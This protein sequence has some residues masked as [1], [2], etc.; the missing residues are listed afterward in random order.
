MALVHFC[1]GSDSRDGDIDKQVEK[2]CALILGPKRLKAS[3]CP[4]FLPT[5][6]NSGALFARPSSAKL[7]A[8]VSIVLDDWTS[9]PPVT[10]LPMG[11]HMIC[12]ANL[13]LNQIKNWNC[14]EHYGRLAI[15]FTDQFRARVGAK[16]VCYY[17][18]LDLPHDPKVV[19][20]TQSVRAQN[21]DRCL[22]SELLSYRKPLKLWR[23]FKEYFSVISVQNTTGIP[24]LEVLPYSRYPTGYEFV[25]ECEARIVLEADAEFLSFLPTDVLKIYAPTEKARIDIETYL[26]THWDWQPPVELCP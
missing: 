22:E 19:A 16:N 14:K 5:T 2:A 4:E 18:W 1:F 10:L 8:D 25:K 23:A 12:F 11:V 17:N 7:Q 6:N 3:S 24:S 13:S 21:P 20:Y 26:K 15:A 9:S